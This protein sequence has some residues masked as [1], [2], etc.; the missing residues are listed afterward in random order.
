MAKKVNPNL[1]RERRQ[2]ATKVNELVKV[3]GTNGRCFFCH[4]DTFAEMVVDDNCRLWWRD[5]WRG[6]MIYL[7]YKFWGVGFSNGGTLRS[8]VNN[9]KDFVMTERPLPEKVFGPWPSW[10]SNGDPWGYGSGMQVVR[11]KALE[12]GLLVETAVATADKEIDYWIEVADESDLEWEEMK[13]LF[14]GGEDET[15]R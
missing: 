4:K 11:Q 12:L 13:E 14:E 5:E 3:I 10:Y 8:L 15:H 6:T 1:L 9:F 2:R 7:H